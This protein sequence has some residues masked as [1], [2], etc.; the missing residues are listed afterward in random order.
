MWDACTFEMS[1]DTHLDLP[2]EGKPPNRIP[3]KFVPKF[4]LHTYITKETV[5]KPATCEAVNGGVI[6]SIHNFHPNKRF[7]ENI[8][9]PRY[10]RK[11]GIL[12]A[13]PVRQ[14]IT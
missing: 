14:I 5:K 7:Q 3:I 9:S 6:N 10:F 12:L 8:T 1:S 2:S 13:P 11:C 4:S